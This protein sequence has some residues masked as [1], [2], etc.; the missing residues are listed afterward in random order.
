MATIL[1]ILYYIISYLSV[2]TILFIIGY[3]DANDK[4]LVPKGLSELLE[5]DKYYKTLIEQ[6]RLI[7]KGI[8]STSDNLFLNEMEK[9]AIEAVFECGHKKKNGEFFNRSFMHY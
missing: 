3:L 6:N 7:T 5:K 1:F 8:V 4:E 9:N 2:E